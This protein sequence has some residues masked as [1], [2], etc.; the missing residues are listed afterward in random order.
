MGVES[1]VRPSK[2]IRDWRPPIAW[3]TRYFPLLIYHPYH[4]YICI[5]FSEHISCVLLAYLFSYWIHCIF[6]FKYCVFNIYI[7]T[8]YIILYIMYFVK[9]CRKTP[10]LKVISTDNATCCMPPEAGQQLLVREGWI[11]RDGFVAVIDEAHGL[12]LGDSS[13]R[14]HTSLFGAFVCGTVDPRQVQTACKDGHWCYRGAW[15]SICLG[16]Y[17]MFKTWR[18][19]SS[20][21]SPSPNHW[22]DAILQGR[23]EDAA[24]VN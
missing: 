21:G 6:Y 19:E 18:L 7:Y 22:E 13:H 8:I 14:P 24:T 23:H 1:E 12:S 4:I 10:R 2:T 20:Q 5:N 16:I 11:T 3:C 9:Y 15:R 17:R